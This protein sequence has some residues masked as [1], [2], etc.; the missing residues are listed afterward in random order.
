MDD[1]DREESLQATRPPRVR[2]SIV[3]AGLRFS[4]I[5]FVVLFLIGDTFGHSSPAGHVLQN[6]LSAPLWLLQPLL[7][8]VRQPLELVLLICNSLISG[9]VIAFLVRFI[10]HRRRQRD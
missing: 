5:H 10:D 2:P 3:K 1:P 4:S 8:A 7:R 6:V 9:Y